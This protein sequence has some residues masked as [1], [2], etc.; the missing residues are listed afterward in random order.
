MIDFE[1]SEAI[2]QQE[3]VLQTVVDNMV[4]PVSRYLDDNEHEVP[5]DFINF[6]HDAMKAMGATSLVS[7]DATED[8]E[9]KKKEK[10]PR[11]TYQ[12]MAHQIEMLS[13]G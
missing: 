6:M 3:Y 2:N 10:G 11:Q 8:D 4:R 12:V 13:W 1:K 9:E 7:S 5:W